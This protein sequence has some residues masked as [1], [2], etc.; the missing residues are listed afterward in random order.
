ME[1]WN[2]T[3]LLHASNVPPDFPFWSKLGQIPWSPWRFRGKCLVLPLRFPPCSTRISNTPH[4]MQ[5]APSLQ[6]SLHLLPQQ[7]DAII[8]RSDRNLHR[9][10]IYVNSEPFVSEIFLEY[11]QLWH[12]NMPMILWYIKI[13]QR[14]NSPDLLLKCDLKMWKLLCQN[15]EQTLICPQSVIQGWA[16]RIGWLGCSSGPYPAEASCRLGQQTTER[17]LEGAFPLRRAGARL[18]VVHHDVINSY[19]ALS[20]AHHGFYNELQI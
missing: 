1:H 10:C 17:A 16:W 12:S 6:S 7:D 11:C 14:L 2:V 5:W 19:S 4:L 9:I 8:R 15:F 20:S 18:A 3:S 13:S